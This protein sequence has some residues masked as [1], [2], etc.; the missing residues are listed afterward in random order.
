MDAKGLWADTLIAPNKE[1][2]SS[3]LEFLQQKKKKRRKKK[4]IIIIV[5]VAVNINN[6]DN[7]FENK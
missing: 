2:A 1:F 3:I 7:L 6:N 4:E 5:V